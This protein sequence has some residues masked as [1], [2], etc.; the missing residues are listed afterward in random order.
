M[1]DFVWPTWLHTKICGRLVLADLVYGRLRVAE[2][3]S[4]MADLAAKKILWPTSLWPTL[5]VAELVLADLV[6]GRLRIN[7]TLR[8]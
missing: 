3:D 8:F 7:P 5:L 1:A 6:C 4:H 2:M